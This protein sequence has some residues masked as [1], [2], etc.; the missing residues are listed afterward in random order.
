MV[1]NQDILD[2]LLF[3]LLRGTVKS[4][5]LVGAF[6]EQLFFGALD[7]ANRAKEA[8][9]LQEILHKLDGKLATFEEI[10]LIVRDQV[11]LSEENTKKLDALISIGTDAQQQRNANFSSDLKQAFLASIDR[12]PLDAYLADSVADLRPWRGLG[13]P[14]PLFID[15][16]YVM[17]TLSE[18]ISTNERIFPETEVLHNVLTKQFPHN[19]IIEGPAGSGKST[20]LRHWAISLVECAH[21][22]TKEYIPIFLPLSFVEL[23][24]NSARDWNLSLPHLVARRFSTPT[25]RSSQALSTSIAHAIESGRAVIFLDAADEISEKRRPEMRGWINGVCRVASE[26]PIVITSRPI[27]FVDG[28]EDFHKYY[29]QSFGHSQQERFIERWF[30]SISE[31]EKAKQMTEYLDRSDMF[32]IRDDSIAGNPLFLTM[33]CI[34]FEVTEKLSRTPGKLLDQFTRILLDILDRQKGLK[35]KFGLDLKRRILESV[36]S[37]FFEANRVIFSEEE[38]LNCARSVLETFHISSKP[39]KLIREIEM[40][41]GL[42]IEDR[43]GNW[44]FS[45]LLFQE[46]FTARFQ[47]RRQMEDCNQAKWLQNVVYDDRYVNV[48]DFYSQLARDEEIS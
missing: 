18:G 1:S 29:L 46:F 8:A 23:S 28:L 37:H 20:L 4:V 12:D 2:N 39:E 16:I 34:E 9:K 25:G 38:L 41:S 15:D 30:V 40:R 33:L 11:C 24:C 36:A 32:L 44:Q 45:H 27:H 19:L 14:R 6:L 43:Y 31:P 48:I 47:W 10:T 3:N 13:L 22:S 21:L 7:D 35:P 42:I 26:S 5:P 17:T